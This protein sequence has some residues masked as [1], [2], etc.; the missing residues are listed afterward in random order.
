MILQLFLDHSLFQD[1][2]GSETQGMN[3]IPSNTA[4][5]QRLQAV[6][7]HGLDAYYTKTNKITWI[8]RLPAKRCFIHSHAVL[9]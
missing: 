5:K 2:Y 8:A 7:D 3:K 1:S 4:D 6:S 9:M